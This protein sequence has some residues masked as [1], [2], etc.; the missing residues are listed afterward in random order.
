M[1]FFAI[2]TSVDD[3]HTRDRVVAYLRRL[4]LHA[5]VEEH[6]TEECEGPVP[7]RY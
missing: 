7:Y 2:H 4:G 3:E 6:S 1:K 5:D